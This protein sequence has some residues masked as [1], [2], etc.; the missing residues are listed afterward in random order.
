MDRIREFLTVGIFFPK[1]PNL[2]DLE[3]FSVWEG[4]IEI[5]ENS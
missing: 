4:R 2:N 1:K 5:L 3:M